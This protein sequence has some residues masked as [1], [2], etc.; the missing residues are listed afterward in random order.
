MVKQIEDWKYVLL[1]TGVIIDYL[2]LP[3]RI[4]KNEKHRKRVENTH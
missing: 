4:T 2:I 1:D 3:E